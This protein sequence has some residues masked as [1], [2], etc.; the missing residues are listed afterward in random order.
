[1]AEYC[2]LLEWIFRILTA[3]V[4]SK[5]TVYWLKAF[6]VRPSSVAEMP[7]TWTADPRFP[8]NSAGALLRVGPK[9]GSSSR[10]GRAAHIVM[11][12]QCDGSDAGRGMQLVNTVSNESHAVP[13]YRALGVVKD[14]GNPPEEPTQGSAAEI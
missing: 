8:S 4:A 6:E 9:Q 7:R 1:M 14:L 11:V 12:C 5:E 3:L 2:K 13:S 10:T